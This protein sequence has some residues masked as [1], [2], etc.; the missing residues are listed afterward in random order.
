MELL[1]RAS[2]L[3]LLNSALVQAK[4]G[5]GCVVLVYGEAGIGKTSLVEHFINAN[6]KLWRIL[7]GACDSLFTPQPLGPLHDIALQTKGNLQTL[8]ESE[9][10]RQAIFSACLSELKE[11]ETILLIEDVHWADEA[12][13]D[14]LKYL[15]RRIRQTPSLMILTY[16]DDEIGIDHPLRLL[17][18]E[19]VS[20]QT[21][22]RIPVPSLSKDA[23]Q[24]LARGKHVDSVELYRLTNGNPFF[25]TEVLAGESGIP[26]TIRDAVL[27][28]AARLS[29][30]A[31]SVLEA[32]AVIGSRVEPWLLSGISDTESTSVEE[33][34]SRGMLQVQGNY[35]AFRHELARQT[36][37]ESI[38]S[39]KK[40]ALHRKTLDALKESPVTREN[41]A[42]L[43]HHAEALNDPQAVLEFAPLAAWWASELGAHREAAAHYKTALRYATVFTTEKRA[44]L[45]DGYADEC[46]LLDQRMEAKRAQE[47]ALHIWRELGQRER[48]GRAFRRLAEIDHDF[49]FSP[50]REQNILHAIEL[51][52][53]LPPSK[54]LARAYSHMARQQL[55]LNKASSTNPIQWGARAM[56]MAEKLGDVETL[57]HA[58][59]S[60]G[61]WEITTRKRVE[62]QAKLERSL[63]LSLEHDLQFHAARALGNLSNELKIARD[64]AASLRYIE[65]GIE[66]CIQHDL[67]QWLV[68]FLTD[69]AVIRFQQGHWQEA[70]QD[71]QTVLRLRSNHE[72]VEIIEIAET[73]LRLQARHGKPLSPVMLNALN[74]FLPKINH[75]DTKCSFAALFAESAWLN[76]DLRQCRAQAEPTYQFASQYYEQPAITNHF[77]FSDLSYWMWRAGAMREPLAGVIEPY[78]SQI[79]GNWK[80]A[81]AMWE[82]Y[83][84][85]YEQ[86]MAL[87][88]GDEAA[89][90]A[91]LEIFERLGARPI[92]EI[93]KQKM[94]AQG[95]R[96]PRGPRPTTREHPFGLTA[97]EMEVLAYLAKGS[98]NNAVAK[99][100]SLSIRTVEHHIAAIL[101]KMQVQSRKEAVMLALQ[102]HLLDTE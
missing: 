52:E 67:D 56:E 98:S 24:N 29:A 6:K 7:T 48:E 101:Q 80:E 45:L 66:Y 55:S 13:L 49:V 59:C 57:V 12:T 96:I 75:L 100:L 62:G 51:L 41:L 46:S 90:L 14:L 4:A 27:A 1:E 63:Q 84:C 64:Y 85:P 76:G 36:I 71:I 23:V 60:I 86:A 54:E 58:L 30:T 83:G 91:A 78:A 35:Y 40:I 8:L 2:Q 21:L 82:K 70:E 68:G 88:D 15:G 93:L 77:G 61:A 43:A 17:L 73:S 16:R 102:Q 3:Q 89:Q 26:A 20:S 22:H 99:Q 81:A 69:R 18:G 37:L 33:C 44:E 92:I 10:N 31:R 97:R 50:E 72:S 11:Q 34:I 28:R 87:M 9:S 5:Q 94:R 39:R 53:T 42:R 47:E 65:M 25:V 79:K 32:A 95:F 38:S 74:E 19:I